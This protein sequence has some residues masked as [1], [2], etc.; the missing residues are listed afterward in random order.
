MK[1]KNWIALLLALL[2]VMSGGQGG[3]GPASWAAGGE[4]ELW[5]WPQFLGREESRGI[6]DGRAAVSGDEL[7]L[8][9]E[10][11][12]GSTWNDVPGTPVIAG[13]YV[14][15]YSSQYLRKVEL[16]TGKEVDKVQ[17]YA[18]PVNQFFIYLCCADGM[19]FVPCQPN[20]MNDND[21]GDERCFF[22]V[23][24]A[25]TL[26]MLYVTET[27]GGK[28]GQQQTPVFVHDGYLV[29]G[30]YGKNGAYVCFDI[31]DE[32]PTRNNEVKK[33]VWVIR[34]EAARGFSWNGAVFKGA[35][36]YFANENKIW[37]VDYK[38]GDYKVTKIGEE[39]DNKSTLVYSEEN[40]RLYVAANQTGSGAAVLSYTLNDDGTPKLSSEKKWTSG[41][42]GGGTQSTPVIHNGR[43]Y[44]GGGGRTMGSAEPFH[45]LDAE[46]LQEQ[47]TVPILTKGSAALTTAYATDE[48]N[49]LVYI[50]L[51]P[52]AP[53]EEQSELWI[54][55]DAAGQT[56]PDYEVVKNIGRKQYCSQSVIIAQDGS[57]IWYNDAGRLYCYEKA[58]SGA[59]RFADTAGH[60]A[61]EA[62][63]YAAEK[64]IMNG[65]S[66]RLFSPDQ[67]ISRAQFVQILYNMAGRPQ[68]GGAGKTVLFS[69]ADQSAWYGQA[70][71]W[72]AAEEIVTGTA[73]KDGRNHFCPDQNLTR[74]DLAVMLYKYMLTA[75]GGLPER[76]RAAV[77]FEDEAEIL[78]YS[79][80]AVHLLQEIGIISG[81]KTAGGGS[82]FDPE[83][84]A[85]RG[86]T[87]AMLSNYL[88][89]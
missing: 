30:V 64:Q 46:T 6:S 89:L 74:Q 81:T 57:L 36:C 15:S 40:G 61:E 84:G 86:E 85:D 37:T 20:T 56:E 83:A 54:I 27:F 78:P 76:R 34:S 41:T 28:S 88:K 47:Y 52:Y 32:D 9:W 82:R 51:V 45:V 1:K 73:D 13:D 58:E 59:A 33:P 14:Y 17:I 22:K 44:I 31:K 69:D 60:W 7:R 62:I 16:K 29:T 70:L 4:S 2:V 25:D 21:A 50:Y 49:G 18:E 48:N 5:T 65:T 77:T 43:L 71:S 24:D 26:D 19:I 67:P 68:S 3:F 80:E 66:D 72:A 8:R 38:T 35:Y 55:K 75:A 10:I 39:Y 11:N 79:A 23:F 42:P 53:S 87:A 63:L 12:T